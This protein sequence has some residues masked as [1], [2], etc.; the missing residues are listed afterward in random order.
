MVVVAVVVSE[1]DC[2]ANILEKEEK[3]QNI[4]DIYD[5]F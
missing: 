3:N 2:S 5:G 4:W 1:N